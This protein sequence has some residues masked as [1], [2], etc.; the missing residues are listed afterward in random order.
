[1]VGALLMRGMVVG[2]LAGLLCFLFLKVVGE[3]SVDRAI[4]FESTLDAAK[5]KARADD[6]AA[7]GLPA[8][9]EESEP[10]L[11][12][13]PVQA[14]VGLLTG[15]VVYDTALGGLFALVFAMAYGRVGALSPRSTA[16]L[17]ALSGFVAVTLVPMLK[18]PANPPSI[19]NPDTIAMRTMLY[20][21]MILFSLAC[22]VAAWKLRGAL[23]ARVDGWN[24][25]L[26]AGVAY[27]ILVGLI[28]WA[29]PTVSETPD[30][31]PADVL[32]LFRTASLGAQTIVW[33]VMGLGFGALVERAASRGRGGLRLY[34][35]IR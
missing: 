29:L 33:S 18:Y 15:V 27:V 31:F 4:A 35:S 9:A 25:T 19:G 30:G 6:A 26:L 22:M 21:A 2:L 13:R 8:P 32:W 20:F 16:A 14:G 24:A 10:E 1:M 5:A 3:P 28:A 34:A 17:I 7:K 23:S 12:S 11:V